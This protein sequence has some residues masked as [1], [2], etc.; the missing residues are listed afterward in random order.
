MSAGSLDRTIAIY[1]PAAPFDNGMTVKTGRPVFVATRKAALVNQSPRETVET[2]GVEAQRPLTFEIRS[3]STTRQMRETWM[4]DYNDRRYQVTGIE[5]VGR[6]D[7]LRIMV[8]A[9][10][11]QL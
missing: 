2:G 7:R 11:R 8:I 10:D 4:I 1:S 9:N 5:E 3:D 6:N